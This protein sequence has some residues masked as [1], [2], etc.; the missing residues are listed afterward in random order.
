MKKALS[1]WYNYLYAMLLDAIVACVALIPYF[2]INDSNVW[3]KVYISYVAL[4]SGVIYAG[5][6]FIIQDIYRAFKRKET[7]NWD[8]PLEDKYVDMA[9]RIYFPILLAGVISILAG[10]ISYLFLR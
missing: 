1:K 6:G 3:P 9:L 10:L 4:L 7:K 2:A 8:Y 5:G